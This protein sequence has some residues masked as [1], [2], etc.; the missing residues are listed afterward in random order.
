MPHKYKVTFVF[1]M[2]SLSIAIIL[3]FSMFGVEAYNE[4]KE[5]HDIMHNYSQ[6]FSHYST[7]Y[8]L[9]GISTEDFINKITNMIKCDSSACYGNRRFSYTK[10]DYIKEQEK[11]YKI[12]SFNLGKY[13]CGPKQYD[14]TFLIPYDDNIHLGGNFFKPGFEKEIY[15]KYYYKKIKY[16]ISIIETFPVTLLLDKGE[17]IDEQLLLNR[18]HNYFENNYLKKICKYERRDFWNNY[19]F[20]VNWAFYHF[21]IIIFWWF[22]IS[23][24]IYITE[25]VINHKREQLKRQ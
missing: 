3:F 19:F 8:K 12:D 10:S 24:I 21:Y 11:I 14:I 4:Y 1:Q 13:D 9:I 20:C 22:V 15:Y 7:E 16:S 6:V 2:F 23:M 5:D 25:R 18:L 17:D